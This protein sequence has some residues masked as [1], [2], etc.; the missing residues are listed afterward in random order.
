[1]EEFR[2]RFCPSYQFPE[3]A[4]VISRAFISSYNFSVVDEERYSPEKIL[5]SLK[6]GIPIAAYQQ[7]TIVGG[8][9][10]FKANPESPCL[11]FR[12]HPTIALLGVEPELSGLQIGS[13]LMDVAET[14]IGIMGSNFVVLSVTTRA[15]DLLRFYQSRGYVEDSKFHWEGVRDPSSIM[16][17]SLLPS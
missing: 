16:I 17:K 3:L 7:K 6:S 1:M 14:A 10:I 11:L 4:G 5:I 9:C 13:K 2:T 12:K 8:V 15:E